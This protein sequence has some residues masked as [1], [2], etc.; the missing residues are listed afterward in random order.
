MQQDFR[1][2]R[3]LLEDIKCT[4]NAL[5]L[6]DSIEEKLGDDYDRL[7]DFLLPQIDHKIGAFKAFKLVRP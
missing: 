5:A 4:P 6:L 1:L 2:L 3:L 7:Q